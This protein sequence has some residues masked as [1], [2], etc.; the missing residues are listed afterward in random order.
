MKKK[1]SDERKKAIED[2]YL[3]TLSL[4]RFSIAKRF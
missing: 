3:V 1:V 2:N 4:G